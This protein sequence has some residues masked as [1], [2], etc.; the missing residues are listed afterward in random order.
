MSFL[1]IIYI[2]YL[3]YRYQKE[4]L[5]KTQIGICDKILNYSLNTFFTE[6]SVFIL[7]IRNTVHQKKFQ[8]FLSVSISKELK[9]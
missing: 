2:Q 6:K 1:F 4:S 7:L 3:F 9:K 8:S 5:T